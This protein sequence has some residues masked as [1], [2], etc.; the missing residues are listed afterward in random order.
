MTAV[1]GRRCPECGS[2]VAPVLLACPGCQ[3]LVHAEALRAL[4][5]GAECQTAAGKLTEALI[6]WRRGLELLPGGSRQQAVIQEGVLDLSRQVEALPAAAPLP[7]G[8]ARARWLAPFGVV[9]LLLWKLK[10]IVVFSLTKAKLLVLGLAKA[11][12]LLSMLLSFGVTGRPGAGASPSAS[13]PPC[14]SMRWVTYLRSRAMGSE[15][16][17]RCS[18]RG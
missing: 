6:A 13:W 15:P 10:F 5:E 12:T 9:W 2:E 8:S 7:A 4:A 16:R 18:F 1:A 14:T 11:P 17:P 3:R